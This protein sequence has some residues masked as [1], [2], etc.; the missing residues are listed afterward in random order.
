MPECKTR[1]KIKSN[2]ILKIDGFDRGETSKRNKDPTRSSSTR[3]RTLELIH[4]VKFV[5]AHLDSTL[6]LDCKTRLGLNLNFEL[7]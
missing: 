2:Y 5:A 4:F 6:G 7:I 3:R 1:R